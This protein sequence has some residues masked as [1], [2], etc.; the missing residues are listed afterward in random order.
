MDNITKTM[1]KINEHQEQAGL[2]IRN[3]EEGDLARIIDLDKQISGIDKPDYWKASFRRFG[4]GQEGRHFLVATIDNHITGFIVG[5]IRAWEFGSPPGGWVFS[6]TV[7]PNTRLGGI[8]TT[9]FTTICSFFRKAGVDKVHTMID[10]DNITVLSFFR[11]QGMMAGS[12]IPLEMD[13]SDNEGEE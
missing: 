3:A 10:R 6:L 12:S 9:M 8:A 13:L 7:D 4:L 1:I 2:K 11:S 5:E